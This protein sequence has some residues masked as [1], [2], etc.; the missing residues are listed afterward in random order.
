MGYAVRQT[1]G[2]KLGER[3][4]LSDAERMALYL[5]S[6]YGP[7]EIVDSHGVVVETVW[8]GAARNDESGAPALPLRGAETPL[9]RACRPGEER[10]GPTDVRDVSSSY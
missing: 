4:T 7:L 6:G 10:T 5:T 8:S 1:T 3:E 9:D 2:R